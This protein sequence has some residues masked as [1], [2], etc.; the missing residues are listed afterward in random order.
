MP[1]VLFKTLQRQGHRPSFI[2]PNLLNTVGGGIIVAYGMECF[3]FDMG[4]WTA[5]VPFVLVSDPCQCQ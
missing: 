5:K 4:T 1:L 3:D 2:P